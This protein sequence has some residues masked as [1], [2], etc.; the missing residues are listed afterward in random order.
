MLRDA[1]ITH[2]RE[3][4][5]V[6]NLTLPVG[7]FL[8]FG[9]G[10]INISLAFQLHTKVLQPLLECVAPAELAQDHFAG[11]PANVFRT[12]DLV[13]FTRLQHPVLMNA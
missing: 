9:E 4:I 5:F 13:G 7:K 1:F 2:Q 6:K 11:A 8:E 10:Q 12:H 3:N